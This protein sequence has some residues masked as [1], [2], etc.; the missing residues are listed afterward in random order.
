MFPVFKRQASVGH[1]ANLAAKLFSREADRR[2]RL[3]GLSN[4]PIPILLALHEQEPLS[5]RE[6][7]DRSS[8]E[9]PNM[10]A[11]LARME[12]DGLIERQRNPQDGRAW[13]FRS[14]D[15]ARGRMPVVIQILVAGNDL[16]MT[17]FTAEERMI[18]TALLLRAVNN[19]KAKAAAQ[20]QQ[21]RSRAR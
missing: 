11:T 13:L 8:T 4:G 21:K 7:V 20:P 19:L 14:T 16:A 6:L 12:R 5:Q 18:L 17:G 15:K 2:L 10:A 1:L 3:R 9:Q